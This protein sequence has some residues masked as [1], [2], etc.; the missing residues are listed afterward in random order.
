MQKFAEKIV[1][2]RIPILIISVLLLVPAAIGFIKMRINYDILYY[3]PD[4]IE[5]RVR[6]GDM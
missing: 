4:D 1:R 2:L 5:R 6:N 3:L